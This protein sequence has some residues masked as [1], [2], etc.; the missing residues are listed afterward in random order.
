MAS[1]HFESESSSYWNLEMIGKMM[2]NIA[3]KGKMKK[4]YKGKNLPKKLYFKNTKYEIDTRTF[5][6]TIYKLDV[7]KKIVPGHKYQIHK[8]TFSRDFKTFSGTMFSLK[9]GKT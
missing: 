6:G 1:Y 2:K 5:F 3:K 4:K 7:N 9:D 8:L